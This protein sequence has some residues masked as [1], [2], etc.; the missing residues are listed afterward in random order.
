[1]E[2]YKNYL[3]SDHWN[4]FKSSVY[5]GKKKRRC[6]VCGTYYNLN[7]H[8]IDYKRIGREHASDVLV[9]C[10]DCHR[11]YHTGTIPGNVLE[12]VNKHRKLFVQPCR[13]E[14]RNV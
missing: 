12:F 7:T 2:R 10:G 5:G 11:K 4:D 6:A 3:K 13:K 1:M 8:H 14:L 9:L